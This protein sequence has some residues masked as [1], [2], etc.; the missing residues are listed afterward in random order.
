MAD[1]E[2]QILEDATLTEYINV[3]RNSQELELI[4]I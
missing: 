3:T 4:M 1:V 2:A